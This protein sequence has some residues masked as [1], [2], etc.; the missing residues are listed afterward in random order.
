[1]KKHCVVLTGAGISAES[2]LKTFRATDG[3]WEEHKI[4]DVAT[5]EAWERN[6][7]VVLK[8][9]NERRRQVRKAKPNSAHLDLVELEKKYQVSII[10]QNIDD[11]HERAGSSFVLHL[12]G[13]IMQA[14]SSSNENLI[15]NIKGDM[16]LGEKCKEGSLLR[17]F[18]VWFGEN[19]P[20]FPKALEITQ[21]ADILV[22]IGTSLAV[23]PAASLVREVKLDADLYLINPDTELSLPQGVM[24]NKL[25]TEG[26]RELKNLLL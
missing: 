16:K 1:M 6:S 11:L 17:P 7:E 25:A 14:R 24:I 12:H 8:F 21:R 23:Y 3:L 22:V 18:I 19:V 9:Y 5:P 20:L 2:G 26:V 4:E 10:T 15:Y 13:N